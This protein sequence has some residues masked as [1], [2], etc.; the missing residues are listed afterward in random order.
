MFS[1]RNLKKLYP[2]INRGI[3]VF[4]VSDPVNKKHVLVKKIIVTK[5]LEYINFQD[6]TGLLF[7]HSIKNSYTLK[8]IIS[9]IKINFNQWEDIKDLQ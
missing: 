4:N 2:L 3:I 8:N 6:E 7:S 9:H 5:N 1:L